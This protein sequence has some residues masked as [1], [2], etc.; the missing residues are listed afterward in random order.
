MVEQHRVRRIRGLHLTEFGVGG[1]ERGLVGE[2]D[3]EQRPG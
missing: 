3:R 1:G 2:R